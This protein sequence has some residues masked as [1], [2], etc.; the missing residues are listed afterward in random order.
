MKD[1]ELYQQ[2]LGLV[3]PWRVESVTLKALEREIEV[4]VGFADTLWG[5]PQCQQRML[6]HDYEERRL[7]AFGQLPV[8]DDHRV[9]GAHGE[10]SGTWFTNG[11]GAVGGEIYSVQPA[12][13]AV[14]H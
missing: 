9:A 6:I 11:G 3:E 13:R 5:C 1:F 8:Q 2:I 7:A 10:V 14:G 12:V 4:R